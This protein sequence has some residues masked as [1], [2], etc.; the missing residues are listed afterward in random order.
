[1]WAVSPPDTLI[2]AIFSSIYAFDR[3]HLPSLETIQLQIFDEAKR[4]SFTNVTRWFT[5]IVNQ[6]EVLRIL[7]PT[8]LCEK[9]AQFDG[10][11][12][13]ATWEISTLSHA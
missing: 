9:P 8:S 13:V 11:S 10:R 5:T 12:S 2:T 4:N 6:D 1:M 3:F 7:G